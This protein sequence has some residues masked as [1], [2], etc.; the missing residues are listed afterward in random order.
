MTKNL[1][2]TGERGV[3]KSTILWRLLQNRR[4]RIDGFKTLPFEFRDYGY[5]FYIKGS[6]EVPLSIPGPE[7]I[8]ALRHFDGSIKEIFPEVFDTT[9]VNLLNRCLADQPDLIIMDELGYFESDALAFQQAVRDCLN[10]PTP[11][12]GVIKPLESS[13]LDSIR[14]REDVRVITVTPENRDQIYHD[15]MKEKLF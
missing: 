15:L 5:G 9:G 12:L 8:I 2:F 3:G 4:L 11:V 14:Q 10:S 6:E 1:F 7:K 13:F